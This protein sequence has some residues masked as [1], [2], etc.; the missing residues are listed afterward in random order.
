MSV[1]EDSANKTGHDGAGG[2]A[3]GKAHKLASEGPGF[4]AL[5][6]TCVCVGDVRSGGAGLQGSLPFP[7]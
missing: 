3:S 1:Q 7:S 4:K 5:V 2:A 6:L